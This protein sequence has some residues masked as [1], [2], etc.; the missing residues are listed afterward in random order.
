M[1]LKMKSEN[2]PRIAPE[3]IELLEK[4]YKPLEYDP[5]ASCDAF[6]RQSAFRAGQIEVVNKLKAVLKHQ[7]GG[8]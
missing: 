3:L 5:D 8:N 4:M 1:Y 2:F 6:T 7:Q